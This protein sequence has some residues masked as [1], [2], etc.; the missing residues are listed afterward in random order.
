MAPQKL[1]T[2]LP[3][4]V[5]VDEDFFT[6]ER[7][8]LFQPSWQIVCH[9]SDIAGPGSY[10]TLNFMGALVLVIRGDDGTPRAFKNLCRHRAA[11]LLDEPFGKC[12]SRIVCPYHAWTYDL[13]GRLV[14]VPHRD[15]YDDFKNGEYGL[16]PLDLRSC[17]GFLFVCINS[18]T[19]SQSFDEFIAPLIGE[20]ETY[21]TSEMRALGRISLREREINWKIAVENYVDAMHLPV[22]HHGLNSLVSDTYTL[23][24]EE[25]AYHI[26]STVGPAPNL[27]LSAM[28]YLKF[29]PDTP[30]LP[31]ERRRA[32][33]YKM[34]WPNL[35]FDMYPDQ[36][37][38]MQFIP[39]APGRTML[40]EIS[41]ALP[42]E[43]RE[44]R[45][46]RY[47]N[48]RINREVNVEDKDVIERVQAGL[49]AGDFQPGP[50]SRDEICLRDFTQKMRNMLPVCL[51]QKSPGAE[52]LGKLI[53]R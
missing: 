21:K 10:A 29:L 7:D 2:G 25:G 18:D 34:L 37:D 22:A 12:K 35:A 42:D 49:Y 24:V 39:I 32:W 53:R 5:Y 33:V 46:A 31:P 36:I 4:W 50:I 1:E 52:A 47:L 17:G 3:P 51:E 44:M 9:D 19:S 6:L 38:F 15:S 23:S 28:S 43:R 48:W 8:K 40:R 27:T 45:A 30:H 13:K 16:I 20:F 26:N 14:G 41:Y 11:R